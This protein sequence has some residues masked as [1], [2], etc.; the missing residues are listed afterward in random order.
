MVPSIVRA[1]SACIHGYTAVLA[2]VVTSRDISL[3][4]H[5]KPARSRFCQCSK[6]KGFTF[7]R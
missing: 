4:T 3:Q 2:A 7:N 1:R 6:A 5:F